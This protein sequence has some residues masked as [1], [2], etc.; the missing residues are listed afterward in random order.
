MKKRLL[1]MSPFGRHLGMEFLEVGDGSARIRLPYSAELANP[2]GKLHGGVIA[3]LADTAMAVAVGSILGTP[4]RHSTVKLEIKFKAP[5]TDGEIIAEASVT[6][7]KKRLFKGEAVV[8]NGN[9]QVVATATGTFLTMNN[10][11]QDE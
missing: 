9:G 7:Q 4:G 11:P 1:K 2:S 3:S 5:V 6:M 10:I 8:K